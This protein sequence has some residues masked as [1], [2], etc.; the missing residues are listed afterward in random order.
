M[1]AA[2]TFAGGTPE[3]VV[4]FL[5]DQRQRLKAFRRVLVAADRTRVVD[6]N[7]SEIV[8]PGVTFGH[9]LLE[10]VLRAAGASFDPANFNTPPTG[11]QTREFGCTARYPWAHD[12]IL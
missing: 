2:A 12:R 5:A 10:T 1:S 4:A 8:F 7:R 9:P 6:V 3:D 11:Q